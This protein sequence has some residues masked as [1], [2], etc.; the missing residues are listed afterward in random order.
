[1]MFHGTTIRAYRIFSGLKYLLENMFGLCSEIPIWS[2]AVAGAVGRAARTLVAASSTRSRRVE[3]MVMEQRP[4]PNVPVATRQHGWV[5]CWNHGFSSLPARVP[6]VRV[7]VRPRHAR[8]RAGPARAAE[9][10]LRHQP[11]QW[12]A[13]GHGP[14]PDGSR[15]PPAGAA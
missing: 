3:R 15:R 4:A 2:F 9:R 6:R 8:G 11:G 10:P 5:P 14:D 13:A 1:M 7:Y 12:S